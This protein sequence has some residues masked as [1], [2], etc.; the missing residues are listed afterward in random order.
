MQRVARTARQNLRQLLNS[1]NSTKRQ[2]SI[3]QKRTVNPLMYRGS[4]FFF[5]IKPNSIRL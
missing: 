2:Q 3:I 5:T 4:P 1:R